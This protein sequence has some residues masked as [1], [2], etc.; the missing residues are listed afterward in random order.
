MS[1]KR[2]IGIGL[3]VVFLISLNGLSH[4]GKSVKLNQFE[5]AGKLASEG[6]YVGAVLEYKRFIHLYPE[7]SLTAQAEK[8]IRRLEFVN[9]FMVAF[10]FVKAIIGE[11]YKKAYSCLSKETTKEIDYLEFERLLREFRRII[12]AILQEDKIREIFLK[13]DEDWKINLS[14][15][16]ID[17]IRRLQKTKGEI[18]G[19]IK[20][21]ETEKNLG[22]LR[23]AII[24]YYGDNEGIYPLTLDVQSHRD[25]RD[26]TQALPPFVGKY[27]DSIPPAKLREGVPN[28]D[29][30]KVHYGTK[31]NNLG[32]WLYNPTDGTIKIN[33][34]YKDSK[35]IPY[36][37]Y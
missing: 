28:N 19:Q 17:N 30:N 18:L 35:G 22:T 8:E 1:K 10:T 21:R 24:V 16:A 31:P 32:G 5:F 11:D 15:E 2:F 9:P 13:E 7:D 29:S 25:P 12:E 36:S 20:E 14:K 33:S 4:Y 34:T 23:A 27:I 37:E 26:E 6:D 3:L